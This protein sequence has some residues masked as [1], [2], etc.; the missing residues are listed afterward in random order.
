ML[1]HCCLQA[2]AEGCSNVVDITQARQT[3]NACKE[4]G[5]VYVLLTVNIGTTLSEAFAST[6]GSM[7]MVLAA[8]RSL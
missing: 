2:E 7:L 1:C 6:S 4:S 5:P 3:L 8:D